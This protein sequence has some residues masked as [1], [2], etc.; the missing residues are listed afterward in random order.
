MGS[1]PKAIEGYCCGSPLM[2]SAV[3]KV[4]LNALGLQAE[5]DPEFGTGV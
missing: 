1:E 4:C 5:V 3:K 2:V